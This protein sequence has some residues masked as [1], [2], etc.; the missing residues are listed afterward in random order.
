MR[1][2]VRNTAS[3]KKRKTFIL[4]LDKDDPEKELEFELDFQLSLTAAERYEMMDRLVKD[5]LEFI[6]RNGYKNTPAIVTR[7]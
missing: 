1:G 6:Q 3:N 2:K 7:S 5:G 4:V